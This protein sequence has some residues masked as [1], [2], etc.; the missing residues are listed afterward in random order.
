MKSVTGL[1]PGMAANG[2]PYSPV[3][4][5]RLNWTAVWAEALLATVLTLLA[6][7]PV[8]S[9]DPTAAEILKRVSLTYQGLKTFSFVAGQSFF[10]TRVAES[11]P[12]K[13]R[14]TTEWYTLVSD[15]SITWVY[16]PN[17]FGDQYTQVNAA[18]LLEET[19][20]VSPL[21]FSG[22]YYLRSY[23]RLPAGGAKLEGE[24]VVPR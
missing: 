10:K 6:S 2:L 3:R 7:T 1:L 14:L 13:I 23:A 17:R 20:R 16:V 4:A 18:P 22:W 8:I 19:W 12:G 5:G 15:G 11:R 24:K 9:A 21:G